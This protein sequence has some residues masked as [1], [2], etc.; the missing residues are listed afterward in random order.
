MLVKLAGYEPPHMSLFSV[1]MK[2]FHNLGEGRSVCL[3]SVIDPEYDSI[4]SLE[5]MVKEY[6]VLPESGGLFDQTNKL[7]ECFNCI[8]KAKIDYERDYYKSIEK[9]KVK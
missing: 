8:R 7:I 9:K 6:G 5:G 2:F 1:F 4:I 3:T